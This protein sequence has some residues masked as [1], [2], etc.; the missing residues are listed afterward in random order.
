MRI[1]LRLPPKRYLLPGIVLYLLFLGVLLPAT[2]VSQMVFRYSHG[3]VDLRQA[4]GY[5]WKGSSRQVVMGNPTAGQNAV[6]ELTWRLQPKGLVKGALVFD[7]TVSGASSGRL[8]LIASR[9]GLRLESVRGELPLDV[10]QQAMP[11]INIS[12]GGTGH[13]GHP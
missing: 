11:H 9:T 6:G 1:S 2:M 10:I 13:A 3:N 8:L 7:L 5:W 4:E 12:K